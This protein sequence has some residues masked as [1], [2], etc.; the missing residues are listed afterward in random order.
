VSTALD[1]SRY[2]TGGISTSPAPSRPRADRP[3]VRRDARPPE[4]RRLTAEPG[5]EEAD[6]VA[7][8]GAVAD[9]EAGAGAEAGADTEA[10]AATE[11]SPQTVQYPSSIVPPQLVQVGVG[12]IVQP[13][14]CAA[15]G[16]GTGVPIQC[17]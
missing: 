5:R 9:T 15:G 4:A 14:Y 16:A 11:A 12:A 2:G 3:L 1:G 13:P 8:I 17:A 6:P 10:G 7:G